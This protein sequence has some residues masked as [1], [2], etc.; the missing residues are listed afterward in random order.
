MP[1]WNSPVRFLKSILAT[2]LLA[3]HLFF[4]LCTASKGLVY[5]HPDYAVKQQAFSTLLVLPLTNAFLTR[6]QQDSLAAGK[7]RFVHFLHHRDQRYFDTYFRASVDDAIQAS[8]PRVDAYYIPEDIDFS[9][10]LLPLP[11]GSKMHMFAPESGMV[12]YRNN[13]P[14]FLLFVE[15]LR[16]EKDYSVERGAMRIESEHARTE[17]VLEY[18]FWDN[19]REKIA[20]YGIY[21]KRFE[22]LGAPTKENYLRMF[23]EIAASIVENSPFSPKIGSRGPYR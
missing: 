14:N 1:I 17:V 9:Y 13:V 11:D 23:G 19:T 5:L 18:L 20:A 22:F 4:N 12:V 6:S 10:R 7:P 2:L 8:V 16:F 3:T 15:D 21:R